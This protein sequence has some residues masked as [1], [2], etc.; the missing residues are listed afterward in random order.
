MDGWYGK[1]LRVN[2]TDSTTSVET[3]DSQFAKDYIGG[4][5]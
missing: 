1:I 2:L 3:V 4:R 5:G